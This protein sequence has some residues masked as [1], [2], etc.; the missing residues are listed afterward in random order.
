MYKLGKTFV[1]ALFVAFAFS[2]SGEKESAEN[3]STNIL[4]D[5]SFSVD[6]VV[7][8]PG[9]ELISLPYGL[10]THT[11]NESKSHLYLLDGKNSLINKVNLN[12]L[13]LEEQISF[14]KEGPNGVGEYIEVFDVFPGERF[15]LSGYEKSSLIDREGELIKDYTLKGDDF[16]IEGMEENFKYSLYYKL[17]LS[18]EDE[19]LFS[20]PGDFM[21]ASRKL[22]KFNFREK[23]GKIYDLPA[24]EKASEYQII[25]NSNDGMMIYVEEIHFQRI[26]NRYFLST[27]PTNNIYEFF[28]E[29][30][31]LI[32]YKY[33][34]SLAPNRKEKQI[35]NEVSSQEEFESEMEKARTQIG[36]EKLIY[37]DK[38]ERYYRFGRIYQA[39]E[40]K[41]APLKAQVFL[42]AFDKNLKLIGE[43][44]IPELDRAP[45]SAFFKNGKLWS[46]VNVNDELGFAVMDFK[47]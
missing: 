15:F 14:E 29:L 33:N 41:E 43:T 30:D 39:R 2:C 1:L 19:K 18:I 21:K 28:P 16:D 44:E 31:S 3:D 23:S 45:L 25:L 6:T 24:L 12:S 34:F 5:F 37:D 46:Y 17:I 42:F 40:D 26:N 10:G 38:S 20:L 22:A 13:K 8:D 7:V 32:L 36:F 47:F 9:E 35:R 27:S 11:I 4:A